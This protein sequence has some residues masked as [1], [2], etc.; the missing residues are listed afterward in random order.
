MGVEYLE[1]VKGGT[2]TETA[3]PGDHTYDG[4]V[5]IAAKELALEITTTNDVTFE[6][7]KA[8]VIARFDSTL[9]RENLLEVEVTATALDPGDGG[10]PYRISLPNPS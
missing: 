10:S 7:Y 3:A 4:P 5:T 1:V 9:G 2:G 6:V 8:S